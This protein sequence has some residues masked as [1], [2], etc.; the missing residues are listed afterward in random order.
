MTHKTKDCLE[1]PRKLKARF[2]NQ[3]IK[4]DELVQQ[5]EL[6]FEAKRDRWN[7]YDPSEQQEQIREWELI[8]QERARMRRLKKEHVEKE[9]S[10]D[11]SDEEEDEDKYADDAIVQGQK[12]W[13]FCC[14][15]WFSYCFCNGFSSLNFYRSLTYL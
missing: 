7:G 11:D 4:P 13:C 15:C 8:D 5:V 12:V 1:R 14:A 9:S 2:T 6:G 10:D 3:D